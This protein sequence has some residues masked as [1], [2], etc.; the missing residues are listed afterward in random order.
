M[1]AVIHQSVDTGSRTMLA[2]G[3]IADLSANQPFKPRE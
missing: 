3:E 1:T 2:T